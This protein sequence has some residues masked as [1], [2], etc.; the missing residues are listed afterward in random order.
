MDTLE[1]ILF[2]GLFCFVG[3]LWVV[4]K[5]VSKKIN[6]SLKWLSHL[7]LS[8]KEKGVIGVKDNSSTKYDKI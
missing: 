1:I 4:V 2:A 5:D 6:T 7:E 8:L 3:V